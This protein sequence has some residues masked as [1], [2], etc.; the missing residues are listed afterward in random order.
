MKISHNTLKFN[1]TLY[2]QNFAINNDSG[3][4]NAQAVTHRI[5][6]RAN[7]K[8]ELSKNVNLLK[9]QKKAFAFLSGKKIGNFKIMI[10]RMIL[11]IKKDFVAFIMS[12]RQAVILVNYFK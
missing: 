4:L 2:Y 8:K 5:G 3:V 10:Y 6:L 11:Y 7:K 9:K 1:G 12:L